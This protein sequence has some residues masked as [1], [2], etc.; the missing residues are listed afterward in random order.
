[1]PIL[2]ETQA[3]SADNLVRFLDKL[4]DCWKSAS[5]LWMRP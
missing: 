4:E 5:L 3:V 1:M 2:I